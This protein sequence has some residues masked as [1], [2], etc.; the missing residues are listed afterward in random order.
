MKFFK[1]AAATAA[2]A[3]MGTCAQAADI[4]IICSNGFH[5][6]IEELGPQ[7]ER[8]TRHKLIVGCG[9]AGV[10]VKEI[11]AGA[12]FDLTILA[13]ADRCSRYRARS[14]RKPAPCWH[15]PASA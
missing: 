15:V 1:L 8:A 5:A 2:L 3:M 6:V 10:L 12:P 11:E 9:L 13:A 7:Y 4:R 14:C